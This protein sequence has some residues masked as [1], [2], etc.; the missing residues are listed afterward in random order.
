MVVN[1]QQLFAGFVHTDQRFVFHRWLRID[2][3]RVF[4]L[5]NEPNPIPLKDTP[6]F[7]PPGFELVFKKLAAQFPPRLWSRSAARAV[8]RPKVV[9]SSRPDLPAGRCNRSPPTGLQYDYK[10]D[11]V[12]SISRGLRLTAGASPYCTNRRQILVTVFKYIPSF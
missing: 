2:I 1:C 5:G 7:L 10:T 4:H 11:G 3:Q 12:E 9:W 8:H 6:A